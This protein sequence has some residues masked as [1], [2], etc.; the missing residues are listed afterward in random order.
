VTGWSRSP[1][2]SFTFVLVIVL[3]IFSEEI[4]AP[5]LAAAATLVLGAGAM[6]A[7]D[8]VAVG[9]QIGWYH[10]G[11][12]AFAVSWLLAVADV[13]ARRRVAALTAAREEA[14]SQRKELRFRSLVEALPQIV[15][16]AGPQGKME[17]QFRNPRVVEYS[18]LTEAE[19]SGVKKW[20]GLVH[21]D[22]RAAVFRMRREV[23]ATGQ[24]RSF[25]LR[26][27]RRDGVYRWFLVS[28]VPLRGGRGEILE[29]F[30]TCTDIHV[31]KEA[32][33]AQAEAVHARDIFLSVASH[34][35]KTPLTAAQ[36]QIQSARRQLHYK[37]G[38][39]AATDLSLRLEATAKSV[40][41]LGTLVNTLLDVSHIASGKI[42]T[43]REPFDLSELVART[44]GDYAPAASGR[45]CEI[46]LE[47]EPGISMIGDPM[48]LQ[49]VLENLLANAIKYG[50]GKPVSV[51]LRRPDAGQVS[52]DVVDHGIGIAPDDQVRIFEKFE[53]AASSRHYGGLGLGL[54]IARQIV[55][56]SG[57]ALRV[58][59]AAGEGST[60]TV[61]LP[62][63]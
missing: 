20:T 13:R 3:P 31:Q 59:S 37:P 51:R 56:T 7:R 23:L 11:A 25:D 22:D 38:D 1:L 4:M 14:R 58:S 21:R 40:E 55:E 33:Q 8:G 48:R 16:S 24:A 42:V 36:L 15:V 18:G 62:T 12:V 34:E 63:P 32:I 44:V 29:W 2:Y 9:D 35:L 61:T 28:V 57:G 49:Q 47:L 19:L 46:D 60:F 6:L 43:E 54:W 45:G 30:W 52:L 17:M 26:L 50:E 53:R 5:A 27:R 39:V 10:A 41:R